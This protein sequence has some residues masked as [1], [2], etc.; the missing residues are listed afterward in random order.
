MQPVV[1]SS[2]Q[3]F[4]ISANYYVMMDLQLI[5]SEMLVPQVTIEGQQSSIIFFHPTKLK[6]LDPLIMPGADCK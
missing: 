2:H 5:N 3:I 1:F 4:T 6:R